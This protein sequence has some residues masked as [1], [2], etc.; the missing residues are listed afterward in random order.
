[1]VANVEQGRGRLPH[2]RAR[3]HCGGHRALEPAGDVLA[4]GSARRAGGGSAT[5]LWRSDDGGL[6]WRKVNSVNPRPMYFSKLHIDPTNHDRVY[7]GGVGL[8]VS[9]DGGKTVETDAALVIHD[10]VHAIW[11]N[12]SNPKHVLIGNDGGL[13]TSYDGAYTWQFVPNLPVGL[14]YHV[15]YD[16][17][18]PFN[19]C[20]GMQDNYNWCGPSRSRFGA[21]S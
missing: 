11:V 1:M 2:R 8:H 6:N 10:D 17:E 19:V 15:S 7:H 18:T 13:A 5:G 4:G 14:F 9:H 21:A 3:S 12:P 20:G 16:M